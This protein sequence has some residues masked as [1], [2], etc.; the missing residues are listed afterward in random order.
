MRKILQKGTLGLAISS[1]GVWHVECRPLGTMIENNLWTLGTEGISVM[2]KNLTSD[3]KWHKP[4]E[5][6]FYVGQWYLLDVPEKGTGISGFQL[7]QYDQET[8]GV[9]YWT[10]EGL[11]YHLPFDIIRYA[12]ISKSIQSGIS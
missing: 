10:I 4:K 12:K 3:I 6:G 9:C 11:A 5:N 8:D 7:A 2:D 1:V